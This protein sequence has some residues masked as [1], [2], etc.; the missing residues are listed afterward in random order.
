MNLSGT[1]DDAIV[2]NMYAKSIGYASLTWRVY[3]E[4]ASEG[5]FLGSYTDN[6]VDPQSDSEQWTLGDLFGSIITDGGSSGVTPQEGQYKI[7]IL[8]TNNKFLAAT[9]V[10]LMKS[11]GYVNP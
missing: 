4:N 3:K 1:N 11:G 2:F 6:T 10:T 5:T 9:Y 7:E 8:G